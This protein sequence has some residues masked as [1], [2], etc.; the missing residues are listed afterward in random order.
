MIALD[1]APPS[2]KQG[3][4]PCRACGKLQYPGPVIG[5]AAAEPL[6]KHSCLPFHGARHNSSSPPRRKCGIVHFLSR[7]QLLELVRTQETQVSGT[8]HIFHTPTKGLCLLIDRVHQPMREVAGQEPLLVL[9]AD[10]CV[11][12]WSERYRVCVSIVLSLGART[13]DSSLRLNLAGSKFAR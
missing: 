3:W 9:V 7:P 1:G 4:Q 6:P 10:F 8:S 11:R 12:I 2:G 5:G 13:R